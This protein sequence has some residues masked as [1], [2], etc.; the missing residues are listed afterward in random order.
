VAIVFLSVSIL[1]SANS[2]PCAKSYKQNPGA[3]RRVNVE[4]RGQQGEQYID[5]PLGDI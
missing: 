4:R 5:A 2:F 1:P 3:G